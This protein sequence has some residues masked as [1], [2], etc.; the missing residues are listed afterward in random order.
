MM[1]VIGLADGSK[2]WVC[3]YV[4]WAICPERY[5]KLQDWLRNSSTGKM[6][7]N[8]TC[9]DGG[10]GNKPC[11]ASLMR[12]DLEE[13]LAKR[14]PS[15]FIVNGDVRHSLMPFGFEHGDGWYNILWRL[16]VDLEPLVAELEK[17]TSERFEVVQVKQ[18]LGTLRFY[19]SHHT[20][21]IDKRIAEA[22]EESSRTCEVCGQP[23]RQRETGGGV[24]ARCDEHAHSPEGQ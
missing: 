20:D 3:H 21:P 1:K 13:K 5:A 2:A 19:V 22:Q 14:F 4:E 18:K 12:K 6:L 10:P 24:R 23:G 11:G 9:D 7:S 16:C 15:W 8:V 17:E